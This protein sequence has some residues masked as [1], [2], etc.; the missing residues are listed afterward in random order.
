LFGPGITT[1]KCTAECLFLYH[2]LGWWFFKTRYIHKWG[3]HWRHWSLQ[4][5]RRI[6]STVHKQKRRGRVI[7][8][9]RLWRGRFFSLWRCWFGLLSC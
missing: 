5:P 2:G 8:K 6:K 3:H 9:C 4:I 1:S 7:S